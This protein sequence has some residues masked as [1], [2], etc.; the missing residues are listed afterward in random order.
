MTEPSDATELNATERDLLMAV[1]A[2]LESP[3]VPTTAEVRSIALNGSAR[4]DDDATGNF[5][6][7]LGRLEE[8]GL[9]DKSDH[10]EDSRTSR[11]GLTQDGEST[12]Q[13]LAER[14]AEAADVE[15]VE[16]GT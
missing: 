4:F 15:V 2:S 12:L 3:G 6:N 16:R 7:T 10:P 11:I 1:G 5:Y 13:E 14:S 8:A 9:V